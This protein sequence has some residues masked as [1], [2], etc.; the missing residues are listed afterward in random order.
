MVSENEPAYTGYLGYVPKDRDL[1]VDASAIS[2]RGHNGS[3]SSHY[4]I[5]L[6]GRLKNLRKL[7]S[8]RDGENLV[9]PLVLEEISRGVHFF[10]EQEKRGK[11][12]KKNL[13]ESI[14]LNGNRTKGEGLYKRKVRKIRRE[15][16]LSRKLAGLYG[17]ISRD[18]KISNGYKNRNQE[19]DEVLEGSFKVFS[20]LSGPDEEL[21]RAAVYNGDN[22]GVFTADN[23]L[24]HAYASSV[25]KMGLSGCFVSEASCYRTREV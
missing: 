22:T 11:K 12:F 19:L 17:E 8:M 18:L 2:W 25:R 3:D 5:R 14:S 15:I 6:S 24:I 20:G 1:F 7:F 21:V 23:E 4:W 10:N 16:K 9:T 13:E